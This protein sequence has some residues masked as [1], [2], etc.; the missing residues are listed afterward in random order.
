MYQSVS[1]IH[2]SGG[3]VSIFRVSEC[4]TDTLVQGECI[5]RTSVSDTLLIHG[6]QGPLHETSIQPINL[7]KY[8]KIKLASLRLILSFVKNNPAQENN[9]SASTE[10]G[11]MV[12]IALFTAIMFYQL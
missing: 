3:S 7:M 11:A 8:N 5:N 2:S 9:H 6:R 1:L 12:R 4:I 10:V